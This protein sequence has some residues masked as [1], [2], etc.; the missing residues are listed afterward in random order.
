MS[1]HLVGGGWSESNDGSVYAPFLGEAAERARTSGFEGAPRIAVVVVRDGDEAE[2]AEKLIA[3]TGTP[4]DFEAVV[5]ALGHGEEA[6][7]AALAEVHGIVVGGGLT[8]A[9]LK[10]LRPVFG[11]IRRQV[12]AGV[13]YLGFSAGSTI[14]S[15]HALVGGWRIGGVEVSPEDGSE[16]LDEVTVENGIGLLDISVDVHAVQWGNLSRLIAATEAGLVAGGIAI[17]ENTAFI[18]GEGALRAVG[19]GNVWQVLPAEAGVRV[20]SLAAE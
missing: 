6:T 10:A 13:P 4:G 11:E 15:E 2:H 17:D 18:V 1:V 8:P 9:Y 3:A 20:S 5:T 12:A 19:A 14:A 7:T 16:G